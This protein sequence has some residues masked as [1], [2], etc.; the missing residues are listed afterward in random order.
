[1]THTHTQGHGHGHGVVAS[2]TWEGQR[3]A[4]EVHA[5]QPRA[6]SSSGHRTAPPKPRSPAPSAPPSSPPP[7]PLRPPTP[8]RP[9]TRRRAQRRAP[10]GLRGVAGAKGC[11]GG[12]HVTQLEL[13]PRFVTQQ[14]G[15][16]TIVLG[17]RRATV[18]HLRVERRGIGDSCRA[19]RPHRSLPKDPGRLS[20]SSRARSA[21]MSLQ[22]PPQEAR[23]VSCGTYRRLHLPIVLPLLHRPFRE[24]EL[25]SVGHQLHPR[26]IHLRT[27][28]CRLG[29][30]RLPRA[31]LSSLCKLAGR[32][33][34]CRRGEHR[35]TGIA[36]SAVAMHVE[37]SHAELVPGGRCKPGH[38]T[39]CVG[40]LGVCDNVLELAV[41]AGLCLHP[42]A[43]YSEATTGDGSSPTQRD[44]VAEHRDRLRR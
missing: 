16:I 41:A 3:L 10:A 30:A 31:P 9:R 19:S 6:A 35:L 22:R 39:F 5:V 40:V 21:A 14:L 43:A 13:Y 36:P 28:G 17:R 24:S 2:G 15:A 26:L 38:H 4:V 8:P 44:T 25:L 7:P 32:V 12:V 20:G 42:V 29:P 23:V 27:R 33:G 34:V 1:M 11:S 37:R 18:L